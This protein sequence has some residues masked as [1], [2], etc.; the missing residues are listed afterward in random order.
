M[1]DRPV[2][3]FSAA[4]AVCGGASVTTGAVAA[5][6]LTDVPQP[7]QNFSPG[8]VRVA[9]EGQTVM[10]GTVASLVTTSLLRERVV[11]GVT[12]SFGVSRR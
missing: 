4:G 1:A 9:Q 8:L 11:V 3:R 5:A 10:F 12:V 7:P 2:E 6:V